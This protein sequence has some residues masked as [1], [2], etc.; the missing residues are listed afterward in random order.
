[1]VEDLVEAQ[2]LPAASAPTQS[3]VPGSRGVSQTEVTHRCA[4]RQSSS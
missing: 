4:L 2:V 1:M 3:V